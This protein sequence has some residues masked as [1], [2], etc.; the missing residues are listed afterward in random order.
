MQVLNT[1]L[2]IK[3]FLGLKCRYCITIIVKPR[4]ACRSICSYNLRG[5]TTNQSR[6]SEVTRSIRVNSGPV[7]RLDLTT[8]SVD[9]L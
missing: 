3:P 6:Q 1:H 4:C 2:T 7:N 8:I 5:D 9:N